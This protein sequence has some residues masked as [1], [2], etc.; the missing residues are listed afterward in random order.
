MKGK[1][2]GFKNPTSIS[3]G[4]RSLLHSTVLV[5]TQTGNNGIMSFEKL[6]KPVILGKMYL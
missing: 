3:P 5:R 6:K 4:E 2:Q 1:S